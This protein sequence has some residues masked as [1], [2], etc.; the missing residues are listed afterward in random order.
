MGTALPM[1][2]Q[3]MDVVLLFYGSFTQKYTADSHYR[4][5]IY[6]FSDCPPHVCLSPVTASRISN[7]TL[8]AL[9]CLTWDH[10]EVSVQQLPSR[11]ECHTLCLVKQQQ[12]QDNIVSYIWVCNMTNVGWEWLFTSQMPHTAILYHTGWDLRVYLQWNII[13]DWFRLVRTFSALTLKH[14]DHHD[15]HG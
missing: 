3:F 13:C 1:D 4:E 5:S 15:F 9:K 7:V 2:A 8:T 14:N 10:A 12:Q 6:L 11:I